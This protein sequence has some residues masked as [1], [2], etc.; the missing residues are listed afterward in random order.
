VTRKAMTQLENL[1]LLE[2]RIDRLLSAHDTSN[3]PAEPRADKRLFKYATIACEQLNTEYKNNK[4]K[5]LQLKAE[6]RM[7]A[8]LLSQWS[9]QISMKTSDQRIILLF[10]KTDGS[11][12][13]SV[14]DQSFNYHIPKSARN[15]DVYESRDNESSNSSF[16]YG[17]ILQ[18]L[19]TRSDLW[20]DAS[21]SS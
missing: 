18:I 13:Y 20:R 4:R 17:A 19:N 14:V 7:M 11:R 21:P 6:S 5:D 16:V 12:I 15:G 9:L 10:L 2:N 3:V 8:G 1:R